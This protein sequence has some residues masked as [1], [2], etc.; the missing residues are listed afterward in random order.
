MKSVLGKRSVAFWFH[1]YRRI[2]AFLHPHHEDRT[3]DRTTALVRQIVEAAI[4]NMET[5]N[6]R[7]NLRYQIK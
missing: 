6:I 5:H 2:G 7:P 3:D 1:L 4:C